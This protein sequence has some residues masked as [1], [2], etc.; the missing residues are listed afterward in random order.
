MSARIPRGQ[1]GTSTLEFVIVLPILLFVLFAVAELSRA[2]LTLN[3]A[4]TAAR[5]G[6]RAASVSLAAE[7]IGRGNARIDD[8][9]DKDADTD[10]SVG[11][12]PASCDADSIVIADVKVTFKTVVPLLLPMLASLPIE[13]TATMRHE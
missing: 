7:S 5:E 10:W 9:L 6:A 11:C 12:E 2:W 4:T 3:L 8:F 13:Q 1:K